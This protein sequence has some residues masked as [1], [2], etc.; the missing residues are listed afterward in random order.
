MEGLKK[1][2]KK[3]SN[4]QMQFLEKRLQNATTLKKFQ[5]TS[6][7][8]TVA[9]VSLVAQTVKKL[10]WHSTVQHC[11]TYLNTPEM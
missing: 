2:I 11:K 1:K 7:S 8:T 9:F 10:C 6:Q 4:G 5:S 3:K